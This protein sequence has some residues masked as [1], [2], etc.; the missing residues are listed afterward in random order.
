MVEVTATDTVN[1]DVQTITVTVTN[2]NDNDPVITSDGGAA[3]AGVN[4]AENQTAVTTVTATD[5]DGTS[6]TFSITGGIDQGFF[7]IDTNTGVL[8]FDSAPDFETKA[9]DGANNTYIVEVT[10]TD[11]VNTD[12]QTITVTVTNEN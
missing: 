10:A 8:T 6:P 12:I 3:T 1:T 7:S 9:D 4:A 5:A 2:E 11:T